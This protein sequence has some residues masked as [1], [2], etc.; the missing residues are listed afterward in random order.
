MKRTLSILLA[1]IALVTAPAAGQ[2]KPSFAGSWK[3]ADPA[4]PDMFT[5]S[6]IVVAQDA[7]VLTITATGQMGEFKTSYR[8]DG[9]VGSS[10]LDF[11]GMTIDRATRAAWNENKLTLTTTS[12][13]NGQTIEIK[14]VFSL[15]TDGALNVESTYPDF[16][17]GGGPITNKAVYKKS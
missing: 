8:L 9:T 6:L 12:D 11:Q 17:G 14:N 1:S 16:Q 15:G 2:D 5:P 13:M 3:L 10:P 7:S 4:Q